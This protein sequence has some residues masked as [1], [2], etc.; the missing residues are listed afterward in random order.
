M[1]DDAPVLV[2]E[3]DPAVRRGAEQALQLAGFSVRAFETAE[4]ASALL[5]PEFRG[6]V[7]SDVKL[8][9]KDGIALL[10]EAV[11]ADREIPVIL[12]TGHG[13]VSMAVD[14]MRSG[15]YDF[16]EKPFRS[17]ELV[18]VVR[19]ALEKRRLVLDNRQLRRRLQRQEGAL[20][21]GDS[22]SLARVR[23]LI[24]A[25]GPTDAPVLINGETGTGKEVVARALH[26]ASER[27]GEFVAVNCGAL[28]E[29]VFE[30]EIFGH[31][32]G[33]FTGAAR[34]RI[35]KVEH[36]AGG[37]LFLDEIETMPPALQV[38]L[39]RVLQERK[40]ER[41]GG[42]ELIPVDC[43][44]VAAT[45]ADLKRLSDAGR[46]RS[47]LYYRLNVA[48]IELPALR[49]R[50]EDIPR[51]VA[52]FLE[53][54]GRRY[55]REPPVVPAEQLSRWTSAEWPGNVRELRNA[56]ERY[57][58]GVSDEAPLQTDGDDG[59]LSGRVESFER[60]L[61]ADELR[62]QSG[63]V[64]RAA[65]ALGLPKKTLYDK[66]R[67]HGLLPDEFRGEAQR[68]AGSER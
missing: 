22:P 36:A 65:D 41:L 2:I 8:P 55:L 60:T 15:A 1:R 51:L 31:E 9:G 4:E 26:F 3:D 12:I 6:V 23:Q 18:E 67:K 16:M 28:P 57:V 34:R 35:G 56:V 46:F 44:V 62:R 40:V 13:D 27:R 66:L 17:D 58:L 39:L 61:I 30:S 29:S 32:A 45:K 19:R 20:L 63:N 24:H 43:R 64:A 48:A 53:E 33:A 14:A 11:A 10:R 59:S 5:R 21:V 52:H 37:T 49:Q 47:D 68:A 42:N 25:L 7:V 54:A 50:R 38:K